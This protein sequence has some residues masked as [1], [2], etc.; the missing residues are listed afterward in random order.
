[1]PTGDGDRKILRLEQESLSVSEVKLREVTRDA[2]GG[3]DE[4]EPKIAPLAP[5]M[6]VRSLAAGEHLLPALDGSYRSGRQHS[7]L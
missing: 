3:S 1:M 6:I 2:E 4:G 7:L 5:E